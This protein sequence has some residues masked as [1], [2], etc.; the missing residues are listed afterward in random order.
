LETKKG[1]LVKRE[2]QKHFNENFQK[3]FEKKKGKNKSQKD[4]KNK[5]KRE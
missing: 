1:F 2:K 4:K 5:K 3:I